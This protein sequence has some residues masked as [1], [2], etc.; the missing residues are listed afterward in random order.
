MKTFWIENKN[1]FFLFFVWRLILF[2]VELISG[3]IITPNSQFLE[4]VPWANF[5]GGHYL[6]IA[7]AG[8]GTF[9]QAFFPLYPLLIG[10][11]SFLPIS[12]VYI[13]L[14]ISHLALLGGLFFL[15]ALIK[16][17]RLRSGLWIILFLLFFPTGFFLVSVYPTS[18]LFF[19]VVASMYAI[20]RGQWFMGGFLGL[21]ASVTH[22]FGIFLLPFALW[23]FFKTPTRNWRTGW[24]V[25]LIPAGILV[26]MV[27]LRHTTGD[28]MAFAHV[29]SAF[30]ANRTGTG[31]VLLP[32]VLWRY[33]KI[34]LTVSPLTFAYAVA[35]FEAAVFAFFSILLLLAFRRK[36][37]TSYLLY[38]ALVI[39][40][41]TL[42]GTFSS[43]PRYVLS[44]FPLFFV[45]GTMHNRAIKGT[46]LIVFTVGLFICT[47]AYLSAYFIA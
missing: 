5:D 16:R 24:P 23:E 10:A 8:Y 7:H 27:Y 28:P 37:R 38:S 14:G 1:V 46:L 26:Y 22:L 3:K 41:P 36:V 18:L 31:I 4:P 42:T 34:F 39:I 29:Q 15:S 12:P 11:L 35:V 25:F 9:E 17:E 40:T 32:Q 45:L 2:F 13:A 30:G 20:R 6:H 43:I 21:L 33:G 19:L 44:A 47:I